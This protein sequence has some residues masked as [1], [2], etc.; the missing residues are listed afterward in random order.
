ME[1]A[2]EAQRVIG[3]PMDTEISM[4]DLGKSGYRGG[5][6]EALGGFLKFID[7]GIVAPGSVLI[8]ENM[9]R[10]SRQT[11]DEAMDVLKSIVRR[12][13]D[14]YDCSDRT[15][16]NAASLKGFEFIKLG[17][18]MVLSNEESAKKSKR[19]KEAWASKRAGTYG[20]GY[21]REHDV[22]TRSYPG[23]I[24]PRSVPPVLDPARAAV[25]RRIFEMTA[26]GVGKGAI[27]KTL[28]LEGVPCFG[29]SAHWHP[30]YV[31]KILRSPTV[32]GHIVPHI[33][34][35][36]IDPKT[37]AEGK[38]H[39]VAQTAIEGYFPAC[40]D[41]DLFE[42]VQTILNVPRTRTFPKALH[43]ILS[44]LARCPVC[45]KTMTRVAKGSRSTPKLVCAAA[46]VGACKYV[47]VSME[48]VTLALVR[49]ASQPFPSKTE[50]LED[51][52]RSADAGLEMT[53]VLLD[54]TMQSLERAPTS[55]MLLARLTELEASADR[56]RAELARLQA[57]AAE[58]DTRVLQMRA[59]RLRSALSSEP[60]DTA[61]ANA[62]LKECLTQVTVDYV[63]GELRLHWRHNGET[64]VRYD[65]SGEFEDFTKADAS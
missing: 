50:G 24:V 63:Q 61:R 49:S 43:N 8:V 32:I 45:G 14:V 64:V 21:G 58:T 13:V 38:M 33:E 35:R 62:C 54:K 18:R 37:K 31:S 12:G 46:K 4:S 25:V 28:N 27:A 15:R 59:A 39:R 29:A 65:W 57:L 6:Q 22:L 10:L 20:K 41:V 19:L 56:A 51:A 48:A 9:D 36:D 5:E 40:V 16:Y 3:L 55:K 47:G 11:V 23:W 30:S 7:D 26:A 60:L 17:F 1:L 2:A 44:S 42:Q 53:L 52:I 34:T